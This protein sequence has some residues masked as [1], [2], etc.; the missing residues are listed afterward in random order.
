MDVALAVS[1]ELEQ[2]ASDARDEM[3]RLLS[4]ELSQLKL[5]V[6]AESD[7]ED[8]LRPPATA[9]KNVA[10]MEPEPPEAGGD[11]RRDDDASQNT[12]DD[13]IG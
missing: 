6:P 1:A 3:T 5:E 10:K 9:V 8:Y 4:T 7:T 11:N 2:Q 12:A 13:A